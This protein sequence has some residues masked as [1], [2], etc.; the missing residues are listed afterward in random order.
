MGVKAAGGKEGCRW[1]GRLQVG[2]KAAG[3]EEGRGGEE[4]C[5]WGGRVDVGGQQ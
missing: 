2:R 5:R 4:S 1:E 3:T